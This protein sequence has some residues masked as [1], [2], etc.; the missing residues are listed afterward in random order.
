MKVK[1]LKFMKNRGFHGNGRFS[2]K[3]ANFTENVTA[4][5]SWIRLVPTCD[6]QTYSVNVPHPRCL[7][8][9]TA[10]SRDNR[11]STSVMWDWEPTAYSWSCV[12]AAR[13]TFS[14][15]WRRFLLFFCITKQLH[16]V[17]YGCHFFPKETDVT[18]MKTKYQITRHNSLVVVL[19]SDEK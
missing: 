19:R 11:S 10:T 4:V 13:Q 18:W 9:M 7:D 5:K 1:A 12:E 3:K 15:V 17:H 16:S 2:W 14:R 8:S 6:S